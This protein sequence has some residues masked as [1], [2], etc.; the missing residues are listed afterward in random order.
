[1]RSFKGRYTAESRFYETGGA[2]PNLRFLLKVW[3]AHN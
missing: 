1:M 2:L 3:Q